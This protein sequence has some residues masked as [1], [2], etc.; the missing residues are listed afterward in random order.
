MVTILFDK[1]RI[2]FDKD[3]FHVGILKSKIKDIYGKSP[4][5]RIIGHESS[6][7][8][9]LNYDNGVTIED[10]TPLSFNECLTL[11]MNNVKVVSL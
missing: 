7:F 1:K 9:I 10:I 5:I 4:M 11:L 2:Y 6:F 3:D 8:I